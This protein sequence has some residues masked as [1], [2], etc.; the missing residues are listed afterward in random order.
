[1]FSRGFLTLFVGLIMFA[2]AAL[3]QA[4]GSV[5][6]GQ[7]A[8]YDRVVFDFN[9]TVSYQVKRDGDTI[10]V[11]FNELINFSKDDFKKERLDLVTKITSQNTAGKTV[12]T[13]TTKGFTRY[14]TFRSEDNIALD[15]YRPGKQKNKAAEK[16]KKKE[17][18][19]IKKPEVEIPRITNLTEEEAQKAVEER[20]VE[21]KVLEEAASPPETGETENTKDVKAPEGPAIN[22]RAS[23]LPVVMEQVDRGVRV[24]F[25]WA[26]PVRAAFF[27]RGNTSYMVFDKLASLAMTS[28]DTI[29]D[30]IIGD[31]RQIPSDTHT[32]LYTSIL[33]GINPTIS[34]N[35]QA[36]VATFTP[37]PPVPDVVLDP[38]NSINDRTGPEV[39]VPVQSPGNVVAFADPVIRDTLYAGP[40]EPLGRGVTNTFQ[41][42]DFDILPSNH[43]LAIL[44]KSMNTTL[45][46]SERGFVISNPKGLR[47]QDK[48]AKESS[49]TSVRLYRFSE[50]A[51]D[52]EGY[53]IDVEKRLMY[54]ISK[55]SRFELSESQYGLAKFYFAHGFIPEALGIMNILAEE[56]PRLVKKPEPMAVYGALL[57]LDKEYDKAHK[58]LSNPRLDAYAETNLWRAALLV[59]QHKFDEAIQHFSEASSIPSNWPAFVRKALVFQA[60]KASLHNGLIDEARS[61]LAAYQDGLSKKEF[62]PLANKNLFD[63]KQAEILIKDK[64]YGEA[65]Q[66]LDKARESEDQYIRTRSEFLSIKSGHAINETPVKEAIER[67]E[68]LRFAWRAPRA[69]PR[70]YDLPIERDNFEFQVLRLLGDMYSEADEYR[71]ALST[72]RK[73]IA[74]FS[75]IQDTSVLAQQMADIFSDLFYKGE[76][77]SLPPLKAVALFDEFRELTPVNEKGDQ[78]IAGLADRLVSVDLLD[79]A[80]ELLEFQ[81]NFR[82]KGLEK[83]KTASRLGLIYLLNQAPQKA[84]DTIIRTESAATPEDLSKQRRLLKA[85]ALFET[86]QPELAVETLFNDFGYDSD[87]LRADIYWRTQQWGLASTVL[88][89]LID[90]VHQKVGDKAGKQASALAEN[91]LRELVLNLSVALALA[92]ENDALMALRNKYLTFMRDTAY[93]DLFN[94]ITDIS[95][96]T[97][98]EASINR[99]SELSNRFA[100]IDMFERFLNSYKERLDTEY[101]SSFYN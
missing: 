32:I 80:A 58:Y 26:E 88:K 29:K 89:R 5:R 90:Q 9:K 65:L 59:E 16:E 76:A 27:S 10:H 83:T 91:E 51:K 41:Y 35:G 72:L 84:L 61:M 60:I 54:E 66:L 17:L 12:A 39:A 8:K 97:T 42:I 22:S 18:P 47:I 100:K 13:V 45:D 23:E 70:Q 101:L 79:R 40:I 73:A 77:D 1:M 15:I 33:P 20:K 52:E 75:K 38:V 99:F 69:K 28:K 68:R 19:K 95:L 94:L 25:V 82:L 37:S 98:T 71:K 50:W 55:S 7:H 46:R 67:L 44:P 56:N 57:Y 93:E 85:R 92:D 53:F 63:Y 87:L 14:R 43:G 3:A 4:P 64:S 81:V 48:K 74:D 21:A 86:D 24:E 78:M 96:D 49:S 34:R 2:S 11:T 31:F 30:K 62:V 36:W 6:Y